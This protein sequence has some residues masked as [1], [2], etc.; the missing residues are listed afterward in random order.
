MSAAETHTDQ[1]VRLTLSV[2]TGAAPS[3][4]AVLFKDFPLCDAVASRAADPMTDWI[5]GISMSSCV[6][7][8]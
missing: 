4:L 5:C 8:V 6:A 7:P 3:T 1:E 2:Q